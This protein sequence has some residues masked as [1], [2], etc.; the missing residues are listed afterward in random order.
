[1]EPRRDD[2]SGVGGA[3]G[4]AGFAVVIVAMLLYAV[5]VFAAIVLSLVSLWGLRRNL[6]VGRHYIMGE[7]ARLTIPMGL[8]GV[9]VAFCILKTAEL[10]FSTSFIAEG[11]MHCGIFSY[12]ACAVGWFTYNIQSD[13][14]EEHAPASVAK[15]PLQPRQ[16]APFSYASWNDEERS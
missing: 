16:Q 5:L 3:A 15:E 13:P 12:S 1:M 14:P 2:S 7:D 4:A 6:W 8:L 10:L 11:W 9:V